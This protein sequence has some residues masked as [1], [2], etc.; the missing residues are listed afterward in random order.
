MTLQQD[1]GSAELLFHPE[2]TLVE[3]DSLAKAQG[4]VLVWRG[5]RIRLL[6]AK[7]HAQAANAA[8]LVGDYE[9]ALGHIDDALRQ[10]GEVAICTR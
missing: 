2:L 3:A 8:V 1:T 5:G 10:V 4:G 7:D 6:K 9:A